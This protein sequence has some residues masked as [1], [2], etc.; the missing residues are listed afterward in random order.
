VVIG[1]GILLNNLLEKKIEKDVLIS[2][3][4]IMSLIADLM[5]WGLNGKHIRDNVS[6]EVFRI[7]GNMF[8]VNKHIGV[9]LVER[10]QSEEAQ[11]KPKLDFQLQF[12]ISREVMD[13]LIGKQVE[14][15][16]CGDAR[17]ALDQKEFLG[18]YITGT[19]LC[20]GRKY[21]IMNDDQE[22]L[23]EFDTNMLKY[24][25]LSTNVCNAGTDARISFRIY[26]NNGYHYDKIKQEDS[27]SIAK[28]DIMIDPT[29]SDNGH[30]K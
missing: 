25:T 22:L 26:D 13:T 15:N 12:D 1:M 5:G 24:M 21:L 30:I 18:I 27:M 14:L 17:L 4:I 10:V 2:R 11:P 16:F 29:V 3:R 8:E 6:R 19:L 20:K 28:I 7:L 9:L 23:A